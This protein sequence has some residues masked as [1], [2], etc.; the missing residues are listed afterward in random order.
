MAK[1]I[2]V[3]APF[4]RGRYYYTR[5]TEKG[6]PRE[7][8]LGRNKAEALRLAVQLE[9]ELNAGV[10]PRR[11]WHDFRDA[12][13]RHLKLQSKG[14]RY[15]TATAM[16][17][18]ETHIAPKYPSAV[19]TADFSYFGAKLREAGIAETS[20]RT[21]LR[22][23]HAALTWAAQEGY[24][25]AIPRLP[26]ASKRQII[27]RGKGRAISEEDYALILSNVGKAVGSERAPHWLEIIEGLWT[28]GFR[29]QEIATF[30]WEPAVGSFSPLNL[31]TDLPLIQLDPMRDKG[32][33]DGSCPMAPDFA[34]LLRRTPRELR[35]G[36][37]FQP[38]GKSGKRL[39]KPANISAVI[40]EICKAADVMVKDNQHATAHDFRRAFCTRWARLVMPAVLKE[41][42]RHSSI[43]TTMSY[44]VEDRATV[45]AR[46]IA[47]AYQSKPQASPRFRL[48]G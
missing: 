47:A 43:Q 14:Y 26:R 23:I 22:H 11:T 37:V 31:D 27:G 30:R 9:N 44:Y 34:E 41:M 1:T 35:R 39:K 38:I 15:N 32:A 3:I 6:K 46:E 28:S 8:C 19:T 45:L 13:D 10:D 7:R 2:Q 5:W 16:R 36:F 21:Y 25:S 29:L 48:E 12:Y 40:T 4:K 24:I 17:H 20:I 42:A 33:R 18:F